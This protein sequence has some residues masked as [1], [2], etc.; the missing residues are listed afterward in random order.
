MKLN[1][2]YI[3]ELF[4]FAKIQEYLDFPDALH[5]LEGVYQVIG[6]GMKG[7]SVRSLKPGDSNLLSRIEEFPLDSDILPFLRTNNRR[8]YVFP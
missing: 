6:F 1:E 3:G 2:L 5:R 8:G 7:V 4:H